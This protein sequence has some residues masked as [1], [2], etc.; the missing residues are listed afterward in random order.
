LNALF[1]LPFQPLHKP[2]LLS[3][4][5]LNRHD[6]R[7]FDPIQ[8]RPTDRLFLAA[9]PDA[10]TASRIAKVAQRLR[11]G[12]G[13]RGRPLRPEHFH[14]TLFHIGD[15]IG[16]SPE[17]VEAVRQRAATVAM[18]S[19]K[20]AFDR[21]GSFKNG[22]FVLRGDDGTIGLEVLHQRLDDAFDGRPRRARPFTPHV[23][24]LRDRQ[25]VDEQFI[26]PIA[27]QVREVVLVHSLLGKTEHRHLARFPLL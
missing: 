9:L 13:L 1:E 19:F 6:A 2:S 21:A 3:T 18:P 24:L 16:L 4:R 27:W 15:G 20:V 23:T 22:A 12:R 10:V 11:A 26:E 8:R 17:T 7:L 25:V 14:V 5:R